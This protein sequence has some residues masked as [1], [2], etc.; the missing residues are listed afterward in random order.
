M[1]LFLYISVMV[2]L[3]GCNKVFFP[4]VKLFVVISFQI[5]ACA[6]VPILHRIPFLTVVV[7]SP[8]AQ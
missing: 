7:Q 4:N 5:F 6:M 3:R 1:N 2:S 8:L